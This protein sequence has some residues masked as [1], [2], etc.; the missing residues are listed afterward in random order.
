VRLQTGQ[1]R[2]AYQELVRFTDH[3]AKIIRL[4]PLLALAGRGVNPAALGD[5]SPSEFYAGLNHNLTELSAAFSAQD[6]VQIGDL[7]EYEITPRLDKL[8][9]ALAG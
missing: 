1:E 2:E 7:I 9:A 5:E 4:V 3:L 8:F 6:S